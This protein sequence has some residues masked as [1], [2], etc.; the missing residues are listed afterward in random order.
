MYFAIFGCSYF[1]VCIFGNMRIS[2]LST[3][4]TL[5]GISGYI[6]FAPL[7]LRRFN[8]K[9]RIA[10]L[11][12][13]GFLG[14]SILVFVNA[15]SVVSRDKSV[16]IFLILFGALIAVFTFFSVLIIKRMQKKKRRK[17]K[18]FRFIQRLITILSLAGIVLFFPTNNAFENVERLNAALDENIVLSTVAPTNNAK[19]KDNSLIKAHLKE[20]MPL[21][22]GTYND[23]TIQEK[24]DILQIV[25]NIESTYNGNST[26]NPIALKS[27]YSNDEVCT[28]GC[29]SNSDE[30][31]YLNSDVFDDMS[32]FEALCITLHECFHAK[33]YEQIKLLNALPEEFQDNSLLYEAKL[34]AEEFN[35]YKSCESGDSFEEYEAQYVERTA[36][37]YSYATA[38]EYRRLIKQYSS[39][40]CYK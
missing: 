19:V 18:T 26:G 15:F 34:Y 31:I 32:E 35:N 14:T 30:K 21:I 17:A 38:Q 23:L 4:L 6:F 39:E 2:V 1:A 24:L 40:K 36:D 10:H 33:Q 9:S 11:L 27:L 20:L 3:M 28:E 16:L 22:D 25:C 37:S 5:V 12:I 29:F 13:N 7:L 8:R